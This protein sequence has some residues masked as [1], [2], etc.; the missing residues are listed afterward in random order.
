MVLVLDT[1]GLEK[2]AIFFADKMTQMSLS[3]SMDVL[4]GMLLMYIPKCMDIHYKYK[5]I[6]LEDDFSMLEMF[7]S[8]YDSGKL[9]LITSK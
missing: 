5:S 6:L 4:P 7:A 8:R 1:V 9:K 2:L 3:S